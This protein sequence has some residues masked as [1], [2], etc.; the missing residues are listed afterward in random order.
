MT[1]IDDP[2][3]GCQTESMMER[4][5]MQ[6][7]TVDGEAQA[8]W[9]SEVRRFHPKVKLLVEDVDGEQHTLVE[10]GRE[11]ASWQS[12]EGQTSR[13]QLI[14]GSLETNWSC[15]YSPTESL[16][17]R[18]DGLGQLE[19]WSGLLAVAK[20]FETSAAAQDWPP[21]LVHAK[22]SRFDDLVTSL[23]SGSGAALKSL[24]LCGCD[25]L[26]NLS[27]LSGLTQIKR[28]DLSTCH[29]LT[30]IGPLASLVRLTSLSLSGCNKLTDLAPLS[31]LNKIKSLRLS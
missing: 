7:I 18:V 21:G 25:Q 8:A 31:N 1:A 16:H 20:F 17:I 6:T 15:D 30:D 27:P 14:S 10:I 28:L 13:L 29:K 23:I 19:V 4:E 3:V 5:Q 22:A 24:V 9:L 26:T 12:F 11:T 2:Q